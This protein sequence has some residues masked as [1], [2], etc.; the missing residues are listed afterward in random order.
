[1]M[2]SLRSCY[3]L[4]VGLLSPV[5]AINHSHYMTASSISLIVGNEVYSGL[6]RVVP[7][8]TLMKQTVLCI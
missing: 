6:Q 8:M 5:S 1:M 4:A 2:F 7:L 3:T